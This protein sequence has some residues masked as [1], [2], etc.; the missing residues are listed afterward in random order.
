MIRETI[1]FKLRLGPDTNRFFAVLKDV[2]RMMAELG[3][4]PGRRW[5]NVTGDGRW[6]MIEREFDSLAAYELDDHNFHAGE[7]FMS[8]WREMESL[9]E[10]LRVE[11]WQSP[12][13]PSPT[14]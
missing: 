8:K 9:A 6:V 5:N 3:V 13:P 7:D 2:Q 12:S 11:L 10:Q 4:E 14:T 1:Y